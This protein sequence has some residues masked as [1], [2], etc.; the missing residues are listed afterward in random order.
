[1]S[2]EIDYAVAFTAGLMASGHCVGMCGSLVSAFFLRMGEEA[3]GPL[4]YAAYHGSRLGVYAFAGLLAAVLGNA[5]ISTGSF[6]LAQ[7]I[8]QV[9]AGVIVI[10]LGLDILGVP[11]FRM[12]FLK[13]PVGLFRKVFL[14]A[15][16]RGPVAG[17]AMGG[18][19]NGFMPCALTL[20][21]A[22][23]A[24]TAPGPLQGMLLM[25]AFGAGTLPSM[26]FVSA[27]F[28]KLGAK[29]RG[30]LLK[31]AAL[32]V[33]GLGIVTIDQGV[34][35]FTVMQGLQPGQ[36]APMEHHHH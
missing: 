11:L 7:G 25:L 33:I 30:W 12:P 28:G 1:M 27:L 18:L 16:A 15:S 32:L 36:T 10:V 13:V 26:L 31:G 20:S 4:T 35:F 3:K 9:A 8:L 34:K 5:L 21:M 24:T 22:V 17:A 6:G 19:L 23:K 2:P 29:M 14:A